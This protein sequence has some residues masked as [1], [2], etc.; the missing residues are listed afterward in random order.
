MGSPKESASIGENTRGAKAYQPF[1]VFKSHC[2]E[3]QRQL[4][5]APAAWRDRRSLGSG[6]M[7]C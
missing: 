1:G 7:E 4:S 3:F 6:W 5:E 2:D